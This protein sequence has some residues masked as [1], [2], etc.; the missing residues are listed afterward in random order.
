MAF[1]FHRDVSSPADTL[2][3]ITWLLR[4]DLISDD[5][6]VYVGQS[7]MYRAAC[8]N[9]LSEPLHMRDQIRIAF[10]QNMPTHHQSATLRSLAMIPGV[11]VTVVA[12]SG[13]P[14][15]RADSG[16]SMPDYGSAQLIVAPNAEEQRALLDSIGDFDVNIF[17]GINAYP[18]VR[19][20]FRYSLVARTVRGIMAE[21]ADW[22]GWKGMLRRVDGRI[23]AYRYSRRISFILAIGQLGE[24]WFRE[25]GFPE[26]KLYRYG[27]FVDADGEAIEE[28]PS[29]EEDASH[30]VRLIYVG[31]L[32]PLKRLDMLL[33]ALSSLAAKPWRLTL[34]GDGVSRSELMELTASLGLSDRV[35]FLGA[36]DNAGAMRQLRSADFLVLPSDLDGWGA[37]T[38]EAIMRGVPVVCSDHC[39][40]ADL[41]RESWRGSVFRSD[42]AQD[43]RSALLTWIEKGRRTA[44]ERRCIMSWSERIQPMAAADYI[45]GI[46]RAVKGDAPRPSAPWL[47]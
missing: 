22:R 37:V 3:A 29:T 24:T 23:S 31:R 28:Q 17:S 43:L 45:L 40:S 30:V 1:A 25:L 20:A 7:Q 13:L 46:I 12:E 47:S 42:S 14:E 5:R 41:V 34:V 32:I 33:R 27:Y 15:W 35:R 38:N 19:R 10:W 39:G 2:P 18:L 36:L 4:C 21:G 16:W 9:M 8:M 26:E 11:A 6:H 44:E